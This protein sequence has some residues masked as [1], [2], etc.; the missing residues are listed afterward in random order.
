MFEPTEQQIQDH[1]KAIQ[2]TGDDM[3]ARAGYLTIQQ[4]K[5]TAQVTKHLVDFNRS[6]A[7]VTRLTAENTKLK[8]QIAELQAAPSA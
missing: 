6:Q 1:A 5:L 4:D 8:S 7:E 2:V 3:A